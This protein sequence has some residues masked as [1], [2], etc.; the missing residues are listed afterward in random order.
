MTLVRGPPVPRGCLGMRVR[1]HPGALPPVGNA[2]EDR[3]CDA[4]GFVHLPAQPRAWPRPH[5]SLSVRF[6]RV[7]LFCRRIGAARGPPGPP[8]P[9]APARAALAPQ[10][11]VGLSRYL[12][13]H[14]LH[15]ATKPLSSPLPPAALP[16]LIPPLNPSAT[17]AKPPGPET[18][19]PILPSP[20]RREEDQLH[21]SPTAAPTDRCRCSSRSSSTRR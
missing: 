6:S 5:P 21:A 9:P 17:Q 13:S 1:G 15:P 2:E 8:G 3:G 14:H 7:S 16:R 11:R 4:A 18:P 19:R 20:C 10:K 12:S